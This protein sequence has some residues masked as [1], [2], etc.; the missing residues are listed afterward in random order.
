MKIRRVQFRK[1][2]VI[3]SVL[4]LAATICVF[5]FWLRV[6]TKLGWFFLNPL[7]MSMTTII[8]SL[9]FLGYSYD[10]YMSGAKVIDFLMEPAVVVL[11]YP[12]YKQLHMIRRQW[13]SLTLICFGAVIS[14]LTCT[15]L[16]ARAFGFE[17]WII[18][19]LV[20]MHITTAIAM[21]TS[22]AMGGVP[23][24]A[25][26]MVFIG[27]FS[28]C[29]LGLFLVKRSGLKHEPSVGIGIG[30]VSHALGTA[31]VARDSYTSSAYASTALILCAMITALVAPAYV[32]FLLSI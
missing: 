5:L 32:P 28:G 31:V 9:M 27:G 17:D 20:T 26:C 11:G 18:Y 1:S 2:R 7:V 13:K 30:S 24:L 8:C 15:T 21:E 23:S 22:E 25:A 14:G 3:E 29:T 4:F 19:S 12:L 10:D 16:L 6:Q